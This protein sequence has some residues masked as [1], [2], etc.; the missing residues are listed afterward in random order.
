MRVRRTDPAKQDELIEQLRSIVSPNHEPFTLLQLDMTPEL[1]RR[2]MDLVPDLRA[3]FHLHHETGIQKP[4]IL[5]RPWLSIL[6]SFLSK[7]YEILIEDYLDRE[8]KK[9]T[10][11][12][13]LKKRTV[14]HPQPA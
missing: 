4:E 7:K 1:Q 9:R 13:H 8:S 14:L 10:K 11:R 6:K 2:I 5:K 3:N 12:Y